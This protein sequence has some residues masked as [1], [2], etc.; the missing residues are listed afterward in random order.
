MYVLAPDCLESPKWPPAM[1]SGECQ[2]D[3]LLLQCQL[4]I[5]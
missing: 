4:H 5:G 3:R 2:H 1:L